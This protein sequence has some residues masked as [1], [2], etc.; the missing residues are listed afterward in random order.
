MATKAAPHWRRENHS[1]VSSWIVADGAQK[2][3][4]FMTEVL[5]AQTLYLILSDDKKSVRHASMK[6]DDTVVMIQD[7]NKEAPAF[8]AWLHVYVEDA[9]KTYELAISKGAVSVLEPRD[10]WWGDRMAGVKD[11]AGNTWWISTQ[12]FIPEYPDKKAHE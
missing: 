6:I 12:K 7:A 5:K 10:E 4:D 11:S 3:I 2:V 8:P 9:D 1:T